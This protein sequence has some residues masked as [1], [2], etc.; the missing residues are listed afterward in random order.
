MKWDGLACPCCNYKLRQ[1]PR[2]KKYKEKFEALK[3]II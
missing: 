3:N 1:R 2:S